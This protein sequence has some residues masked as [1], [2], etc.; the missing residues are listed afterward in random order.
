[1]A[2]TQF[3]RSILFGLIAATTLTGLVMGGLMAR[4]VASDGLTFADDPQ[5]I[6]ALETDR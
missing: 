6:L 5:Q 1:M 4:A 2:N 3:L